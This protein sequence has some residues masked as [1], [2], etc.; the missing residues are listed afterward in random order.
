MSITD[1]GGLVIVQREDE[2]DSTCVE[3]DA[4]SLETVEEKGPE[5]HSP[6]LR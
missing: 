2:G 5:L 1:E 3:N 6:K 4:R